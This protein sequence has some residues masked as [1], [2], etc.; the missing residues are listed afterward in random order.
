MLGHAGLEPTSQSGVCLA[1]RQQLTAARQGTC[2]PSLSAKT[3][4]SV[5]DTWSWGL[6]RKGLELFTGSYADSSLLC[7]K[8][9]G[10]WPF[11]TLR[12]FWKAV[13]VLRAPCPSHI[14]TKLTFNSSS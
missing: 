8:G 3:G 11:K 14:T 7:G 9:E 2:H 4:I 6:Y 13:A 5:S 1:D 12:T 10:A